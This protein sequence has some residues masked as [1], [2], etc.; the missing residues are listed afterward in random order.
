MCDDDLR[1]TGGGIGRRACPTEPMAYLIGA[2][3]ASKRPCWAPSA[4][5]PVGPVCP[6]RME[7][8]SAAASLGSGC[9]AEPSESHARM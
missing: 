4:S 3:A 2:R 6:S 7:P 8:R 9:G 1:W 5:L